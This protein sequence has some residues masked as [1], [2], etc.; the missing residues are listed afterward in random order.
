MI[1]T[2]LKEAPA[3]D[4][5]GAVMRFQIRP[6]PRFRRSLFFTGPCGKKLSHGKKIAAPMKIKDSNAKAAS[7]ER[8]YPK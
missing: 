8:A 1:Q 3:P 5:A 6:G 4:E 7:I 2:G